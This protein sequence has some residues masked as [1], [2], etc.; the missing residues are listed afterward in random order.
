MASNKAAK[1]KS[2]RTRVQAEAGEAAVSPFTARHGDYRRDLIVDLSGELGGK[3]QSMV[4]VLRNV[5]VTSVDRW[6][7]LGGPG[8]EEPQRR[9]IDHVRSLWTITG[10][11]PRVTAHYDGLR[12]PRG[13]GGGADERENYLSTLHALQRYEREF[14]RYVWEAFERVVRFDEPAGLA[15][16]RMAKNAAQQQAH[17]KACVGFVASKIAEWKRY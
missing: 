9:A 11:G 10:S 15:G 3:R 14:P 16:S 1:R 12:I 6:L 17:A 5:A 13:P 7:S 2:K 4:R 8:F